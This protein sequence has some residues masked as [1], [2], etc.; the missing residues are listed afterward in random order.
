MP[1]LRGG[2]VAVTSGST[3][4]VGTN[5]DFVANARVGDAFVGPDGL[6]YEIG[7][8]ASPTQLSIIPAYKG[9]TVSGSAY[10]IMP[11][12]GYPKLLADAFNSLKNQFGGVLAVL[13]EDPTLVG[14]RA[15]LGL[16]DA[17]G[18][19]DGSTNKYF[20]DAR[21]RA[22]T[23]AGFTLPGEA[24]AVVATDNVLAA[25]AKLQFSKAGKGQNGDITEITGLTVP[26]SREQ[27]GNGG[28][29]GYI[30]GL[31]LTWTSATSIVIGPGS[32]YVPSAQ[33]V[34]AYPGGTIAPSGAANTSIHIYL[35]AAGAIEQSGTSPARYY[36]QAH[37]KTGDN[38][39]RYIGSLLAK[40]TAN[41]VYKFE[42]YPDQGYVCYKHAD[43]QTAPFI[44]LSAVSGIASF[45]CRPCTP[46]TAHTL[47]GAWQ[48]PGSAGTYA[49][50]TPSD[51][52]TAITTG[53]SIFVQSG[54]VQNARCAISSDGTITYQASGNAKA[55]VYCIGYYFDR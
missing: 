17:D 21:V 40:T 13:G 29:L 2:T 39:R 3:T 26:L 12:Q 10:A 22:A 52:G 44:L 30:E 47:E 45:S 55:S 16:T 43:P 49:Q 38:T 28:A 14:V 5:A 18:L 34:V 54:Q 51:A 41:Q 1:W 4:V 15:A 19:P 23:L 6:N 8:I 20:T 24:S 31:T 11:V 48:N 7:N 37:Q 42:H 25:L 36:N 53:W 33:K 50:F 35:T 46:V 32:A 9:A 27:G